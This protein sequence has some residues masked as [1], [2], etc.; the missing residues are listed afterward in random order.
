MR[1]RHIAAV[2]AVGAATAAVIAFGVPVGVVIEVALASGV[3]V[4]AFRLLALPATGPDPF[5]AALAR[6]TPARHDPHATMARQVTTATTSAAATHRLLRPV[7]HDAASV[8][9]RRHGI[10]LD[11]D[12]D[13]AAH[14]VGDDL[15]ELIR[16][17]RPR[18][19]ADTPPWGRGDIAAA[20]DRLE[21]L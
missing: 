13:A 18:P 2:L 12:Q 6:H 15:W 19:S 5:E 4:A 16:P 3:T 10:V 14:A 9:L 17:G 7:L 21:H 1:P 11:D 20:L 8:R